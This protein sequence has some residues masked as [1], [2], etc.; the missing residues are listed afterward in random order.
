MF[1]LHSS[2]VPVCCSCASASGPTSPRFPV[3]Q[4]PTPLPTI[5][6]TTAPTLSPATATP[7]S[8]TSYTP[9]D[10]SSPQTV[11]LVEALPWS[12]V[13]RQRV[14]FQG[15]VGRSGCNVSVLITH[16]QSD[17]VTCFG[18]QQLNFPLPQHCGNR[19]DA[20]SRTISVLAS[21]CAVQ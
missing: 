18:S 6:T 19:E 17:T 5:T 8:T 15:V 11:T 20:C 1:A 2:S 14:L 9:S 12:G 7:E 10:E 13:V 16:P 3:S 4:W 21:S